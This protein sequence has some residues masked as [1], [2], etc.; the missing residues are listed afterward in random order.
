MCMYLEDMYVCTYDHI[1]TYMYVHAY[2]ISCLVTRN[3]WYEVVVKY[4]V[5]SQMYK[6]LKISTLLPIYISITTCTEQLGIKPWVHTY[7][8]VRM[9]MFVLVI[10]DRD[11]V[12]FT[13]YCSAQSHHCTYTYKCMFIGVCIC[14]Y[15]CMYSGCVCIY[16]CMICV[17]IFGCTL[18]YMYVHIYLVFS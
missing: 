3:M 16:S 15:V 5:V 17:C 7:I 4:R 10:C 12:F 8:Y 14:M 18:H 9:Y 2:T 11:I 1:T 13:I 6:F